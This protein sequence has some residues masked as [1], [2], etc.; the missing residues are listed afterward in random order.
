MKTLREV[1]RLRDA[2][3]RLNPDKCHFCRAE[4]KYP[5][6]IVNRHGIRTDPDKVGAIRN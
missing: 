2:K 4:L 5:R 6:H 1:F 3:L